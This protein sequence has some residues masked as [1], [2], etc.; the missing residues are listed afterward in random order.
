MHEYLIMKFF[1]RDMKLLNLWNSCNNSSDKSNF[2]GACFKCA[3]IYI[4]L[5]E[6]CCSPKLLKTIFRYNLLENLQL[7]RP[8]IDIDGP[9]VLDCVGE[10]KELW[11]AMDHIY[12]SNKDRSSRAMKFFRKSVYPVVKEKLPEYEKEV[13]SLVSLDYKLPRKLKKIVAEYYCRNIGN[14]TFHD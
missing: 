10:K 8:L 4:L 5:L 2:C 3:F 14:L 7:V 1:L 6:N 11:V 9:K 13:N 12:R